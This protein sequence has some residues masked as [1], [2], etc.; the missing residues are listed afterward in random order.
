MIRPIPLHDRDKFYKNKY[1]NTI[2][3]VSLDNLGNK[4]FLMIIHLISHKNLIT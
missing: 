4:L 2:V 1:L 3:D